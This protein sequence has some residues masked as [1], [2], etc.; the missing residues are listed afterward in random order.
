MPI[1]VKPIPDDYR[2][3][4][5]YLNVNDGIGAID[6]YKK[7]F[8]ASERIRI[9]RKD[10]K[11]AHGELKIGEATIMLRDEIP[12][13]HFLSLQSVG[14][15]P[16]EILIYVGDVDALVKQAS[17]AGAKVVAPTKEQFHGDLMAILEDPFGHT[18]FFATRIL[19]LSPEELRARATEWGI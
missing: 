15:T 2:G 5:P 14:G 17:A 19:D 16:S 3:A 6:F 12:E 1:R 4:I 9:L 11:L 13:M 18:W 10:G 8:G 7:A